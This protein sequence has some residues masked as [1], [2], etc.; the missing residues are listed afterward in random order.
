MTKCL[1]S[2]EQERLG[3]VLAQSEVS[4]NPNRLKNRNSAVSI[5]TKVSDGQPTEFASVQRSDGLQSV[6]TKPGFKLARRLFSI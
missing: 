3:A 4:L 5:V 1:L 6:W 2:N